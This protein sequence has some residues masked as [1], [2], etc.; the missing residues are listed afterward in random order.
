MNMDFFAFFSM[1]D[2]LTSHLKGHV[3]FGDVV[4]DDQT[5]LL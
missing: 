1:R 5:L 4:E 3:V 2:L